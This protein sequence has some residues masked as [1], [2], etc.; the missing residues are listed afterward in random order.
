VAVDPADAG[1]LVAHPLVHE[2]VRRTDFVQQRFAEVPQPVE[3]RTG[4]DGRPVAVGC[5]VAGGSPYAPV[6]VGAAQPVGA[7]NWVTGYDLGF[8]VRRADTAGA[9]AGYG[10]WL[11]DWSI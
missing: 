5:A 9:A 7:Q 10:S 11:C 1:H 2:H 3:D 6:E 8:L 4:D